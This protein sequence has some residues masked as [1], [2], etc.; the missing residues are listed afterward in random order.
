MSTQH[1]VPVQCSFV[2]EPPQALDVPY[3]QVGDVL[4][5]H[6]VPVQLSAGS[7]PPHDP[8]VPL[9]QTVTAAAAS[10]KSSTGT[11]SSELPP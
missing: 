10:P 1:S 11:L 6:S 8:D 9:T 7:L 3:V 2:S 5:Q 4:T